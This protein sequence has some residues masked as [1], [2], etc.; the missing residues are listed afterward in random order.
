MKEREQR[1]LQSIL[2]RRGS[3]IELLAIAVVLALGVSLVANVVSDSAS[4]PIELFIGLSI[5]AVSVLYLAFRYL[6]TNRTIRFRGS[7]AYDVNAKRVKEIPQYQLSGAISRYLESAFKEKKDLELQWESG[8]IKSS[9]SHVV[10]WDPLGPPSPPK[11]SIK[12]LNEALEYWTISELSSHLRWYFIN[13]PEFKAA[14]LQEYSYR[15]IS[16][17]IRS[18]TFVDLFAKPPA[19]RSPHA[20]EEK[21]PTDGP[22]PIKWR[23][24]GVEVIRGKEVVLS[25]SSDKGSYTRMNLVLPA[26]GTI[27][28]DQDGQLLVDTKFLRLTIRLR[29]DDDPHESLP[30]GFMKIYVE[31]SADEVDKEPFSG[32]MTD[33]GVLGEVSIKI[34][35]RALFSR[36]AWKYYMWADSFLESVGQM[37][38]VHNFLERI[39]WTQ[40]EAQLH[41]EEGLRR[42]KR[43]G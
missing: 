8:P 27:S 35:S 28:R 34:K 24:I 37:A 1:P 15:H 3:V 17:A 32:Q 11:Q 10:G 16:P 7:L 23:A 36:R 40:I 43:L 14:L 21:E 31:P 33:L 5:V 13:S 41:A 19:D 25:E 20:K 2:S 6:Q 42:R 26:K 38:D 39:N 30:D 22:Q 4:L 18:N 9:L 29:Y 12:L